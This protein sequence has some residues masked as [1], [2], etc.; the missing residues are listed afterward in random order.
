MPLTDQQKLLLPVSYPEAAPRHYPGCQAQWFDAYRQPGLLSPY[1]FQLALLA[2]CIRN[3]EC[4]T[5]PDWGA[6]VIAGA[7]I[8]EAN[9]HYIIPPD[10]DLRQTKEEMVW[11]VLWHSLTPK[12]ESLSDHQ[13]EEKQF[14]GLTLLL[15]WPRWYHPAPDRPYTE[16]DFSQVWQLSEFPCSWMRSVDRLRP[17]VVERGRKVLDQLPPVTVELIRQSAQHTP[18]MLEIVNRHIRATY[19]W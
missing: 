19:R 15:F 3:H 7:I 5:P 16:S 13:T 11:E 10:I 8:A 9:G 6:F 12:I 18:A 14:Y 17:D 4:P 2:A 1:N